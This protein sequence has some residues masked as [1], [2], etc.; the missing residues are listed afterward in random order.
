[1]LL[2]WTAG[3]T[4]TERSANNKGVRKGNETDLSSG[5]STADREIGDVYFNTD[6]GFLQVQTGG[7]ATDERGN[8]TTGP[9]VADE[10]EV[11]VVGDTP[12]K[13]KEFGYA[14]D[15]AGFKGNQLTIV[16]EFKT[17]DGGSTAHLRVRLDGA[18]GGG[19]LDLQTTSTDF[20]ILT[21]TIDISG[22]ADGKHTVEI[23]M[24]D[25]IGH[26]I[27]N[28]LLEIYGI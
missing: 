7:G 25:G 27:T 26:T 11:T 13:V 16:A 9:L 1:M 20:V 10:T 12:V 23:Y 6:E 5:I 19:E 8:L 2:K 17:S 18:G 22:L 15:P 3:D 24:D 4:I 21:G 28:V 14:K